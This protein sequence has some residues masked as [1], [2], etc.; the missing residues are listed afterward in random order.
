MVNMTAVALGDD[1]P[2]L[3]SR[4]ASP[5]ITKV[6]PRIRKVNEKVKIKTYSTPWG[7]CNT[8]SMSLKHLRHTL[9]MAFTV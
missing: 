8:F 6:L 2:L 3:S 4:G 5:S 9:T 7:W 1:L